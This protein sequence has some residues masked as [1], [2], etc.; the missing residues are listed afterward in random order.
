MLL[1]PFTA[2]VLPLIAAILM[3]PLA[4]PPAFTCEPDTPDGVPP[5]IDPYAQLVPGSTI[6]NDGIW[7][8]IPHDGRL[9]IADRYI[10]ASGKFEE[11]RGTKMMWTRGN[12]VVGPLVITGERLDAVAPAAVDLVYLD[13]RQY[14]TMGFTPS[15]PTF[16]SP[17]CW[18]ING[19]VGNHTLAFTLEVLFVD[20]DT[21]P[22]ATPNPFEPDARSAGGVNVIL[23]ANPTVESDVVTAVP[24]GT[25]LITRDDSD[26]PGM[27]LEETDA[28]G[29]RWVQA[30]TQDG[31]EGWI[32]SIDVTP[33]DDKATDTPTDAH[34]RTR[35][36]GG[37]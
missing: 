11:W 29:L 17:G 3:S 35:P 1:Q 8:A 14:G 4:T 24:P 32:R 21:D 16:P 23:R 27:P 30:T 9:S 26:H 5:P 31:D 28:V 34:N 2:L 20:A 7:A 15:W 22:P 6:S 13:G 10:E 25:P 37:H 12:G 18:E 19:R 33:L 36:M